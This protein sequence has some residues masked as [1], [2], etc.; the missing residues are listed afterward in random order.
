[1]VIASYVFEVSFPLLSNCS[2]R[3][4]RVSRINKTNRMLQPNFAECAPWQ[5]DARGPEPVLAQ[6]THAAATLG[7]DAAEAAGR[8]EAVRHDLRGVS[9]NA[10]SEP[11]VFFRYRVRQAVSWMCSS[12]FVRHAHP[13]AGHAADYHA[14]AVYLARPDLLFAPPHFQRTAPSSPCGSSVPCASTPR[15]CS[16]RYLAQ[17]PEARAEWMLTHKLKHDPRVTSIG[18]FLRRY[19]LDELPQI[20]NVL[21]GRMSD[22]RPA[23]HRRR[24]GGEIRRVLRALLPRQARGHRPLAGFRTQQGQLSQPGPARLRIRGA[25]ERCSATSRSCSPR[26]GRSST[27]TA[28]T[29]AGRESLLVAAPPAQ[30]A[31]DLF[32]VAL[33]LSSPKGICGCFCVCLFFTM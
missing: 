9:R 16:M 13:G 22:R 28:P 11:A 12:P 14:G 18:L 24:R 10:T 20:W 32:V 17:H 2:G 1:M 23:P 15:R 6:V 26:P 7:Y 25:V 33:L 29:K 21:T 27:R 4:S 8:S 31:P 3:I 30:F 5:S 19:S